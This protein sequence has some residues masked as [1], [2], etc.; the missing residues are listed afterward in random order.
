MKRYEYETVVT[1]AKGAMGGKVD[2]EDF[3]NMLN[4]MGS[5]GWELVQSIPSAQTQGG[6]R[7]I[8]STFKREKTL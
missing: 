8:L 1:D 6:T 4:G 7:Y 2:I 3:D 5:Q